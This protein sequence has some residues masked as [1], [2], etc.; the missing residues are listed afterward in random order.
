MTALDRA[1]RRR[2]AQATRGGNMPI[3]NPI[4]WSVDQLRFAA[5]AV[6]TAGQDVHPALQD[7]ATPHVMRIGLADLR[8]ALARGAQD[9]GANRSDVILLCIIYPLIGLVLARLASGTE[10]VPL[11][12]PLAAGFALVGPFAGVGMYEISRR[13]ELGLDA[14]W[15]DALGLVRTHAFGPILLL[16]LILVA[17]FV[18]WMMA[19]QAIY[20][21]TLGPE[22]PASFG[23]FIRDVFLTRG[24]WALIVV[25]VGVGF[26]F[27][28]LTLAIG[29]VSFPLLVERNVG[30]ETAVWTSVRAVAANPGPMAVWGMIVAAGLVIGT[31][32]LFLGLIIILPILGHATWHLYRR[33]VVFV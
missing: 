33:A 22:A 10:A 8:E 26:L 12:F 30:V 5:Q 16:G 27:A 29:V 4:E 6:E 24:G 31:V 11:L 2:Q 1:A 9:F 21:L 19:A 28:A 32:P 20:M 17:L 15:A 14:R 3:R 23:A 13:R 25:G 18:L 7:G